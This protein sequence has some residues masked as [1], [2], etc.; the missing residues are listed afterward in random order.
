VK[1]PY[2]EA[3]E[4][5]TKGFK[6]KG[7]GKWDQKK[8][9]QKLASVRDLAKEPDEHFV[10]ERAKY[11]DS[12]DAVVTALEA[13]EKVTVGGFPKGE[14]KPKELPP[15]TVPEEAPPEERKKGKKEKAP[16]EKPE[17]VGGVQ[18]VGVID[19]I[20]SRLKKAS[21]RKPVGKRDLLEDLK[22]KFPDRAAEGM[23]STIH[24]QVP[25]TLRKRGLDVR[26]NEKGFWIADA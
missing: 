23:M 5:L 22:E 19:L 26:R 1:I 13:G 14:K 9:E 15:D 12:F 10:A 20:I 16:K 6:L 4:L 24:T 2:E 11:R 8:V 17:K 25:S 3:V 7:A 18:K 21:E